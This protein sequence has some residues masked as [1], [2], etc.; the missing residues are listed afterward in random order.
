MSA[1]RG[2]TSIV[3]LPNLVSHVQELVAGI[4]A[5]GEEMAQPREKV[6]NGGDNERRTIAVL[7]VGGM[8]LGADAG[9]VY[10]LAKLK[11]PLQPRRTAAV[12]GEFVES[13][14]VPVRFVYESRPVEIA[15]VKS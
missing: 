6:V 2:T 14:S 7:H 5:V 12:V 10:N 9:F 1:L 11:Y 8:H 15:L 13:A 3:Q 4:S